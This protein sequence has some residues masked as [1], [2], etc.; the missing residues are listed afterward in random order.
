MFICLPGEWPECDWF[1]N[2]LANS[3]GFAR[4]ADL[5]LEDDFAGEVVLAHGALA[6]QTA[7]QRPHLRR[8]PFRSRARQVAVRAIVAPKMSLKISF[9]NQSRGPSTEKKRNTASS[10]W[11]S[12]PR[13]VPSGPEKHSP[14]SMESRRNERG[15]AIA[16][17]SSTRNEITR[18]L[19]T[20]GVIAGT[21][22]VST[23][24]VP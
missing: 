9:E 7:P 4:N 19:P 12:R 23:T 16:S 11:L 22:R 17:I 24:Y 1:S 13:I 8:R 14:V 6:R 20:V 3:P 21:T 5:V 10:D 18:L 15:G 2:S